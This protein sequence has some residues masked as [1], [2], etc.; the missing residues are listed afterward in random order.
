MKKEIKEVGSYYM[1]VFFNDKKEIIDM[2]V[3][4]V[5]PH[6]TV[7]ST[8]LNYSFEQGFT[9]SSLKYKFNRNEKI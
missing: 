2:E 1:V 4:Y 8:A 6:K 3:L 9:Y 5:S 7:E